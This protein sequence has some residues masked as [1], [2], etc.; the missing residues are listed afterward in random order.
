MS[1][2]PKAL[3]CSGRS[4]INVTRKS[5]FEAVRAMTWKG[6]SEVLDWWWSLNLEHLE[7]LGGQATAKPPSISKFRRLGTV[8]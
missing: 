8:Q 3:T 5:R 2:A 7:H 1:P 6:R 4:E